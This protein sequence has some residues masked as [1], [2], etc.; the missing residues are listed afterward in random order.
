MKVLFSVLKYKL[1]T[2]ETMNIGILFHNLDTDER[3]LETITKW[4]RLK[5]FDDEI[6][7]KFFKIILEGMK[8]E[9][10]STLLNNAIEFD[11]KEYTQK[12]H[13][14]L[15]FSAIY[16]DNIDDFKNFIN[17]SKKIFLRYDY[18]KKDRPDKNEQVGI[19]KRLMKVQKIKYSVKSPIGTYHEYINYDYII[20]NYAFKF[21]KFEN[22]KM[23]NLIHTAK[24]WAYTAEEMKDF[25]K[26][27][28]VYDMDIDNKKFNII[29]DILKKSSHR[30][31]NYDNAVE[32]ILEKCNSEL[33]AYDIDA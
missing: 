23:E 28:F 2:N 13:N 1:I 24:A 4:D 10:H 15:R 8:D 5:K 17:Y 21:F 29:I 32:F 20:G 19:M 16:E 11:I 3:K 22:K 33:Q 25:Y 6:N 30:V 27:I 26:T 18:D 14:E 7:I 31:I 12:F 9:I